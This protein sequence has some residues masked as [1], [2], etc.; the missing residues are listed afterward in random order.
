MHFEK[1]CLTH[2]EW[3]QNDILDYEQLHGKI[4]KNDQTNLI[5]K[6]VRPVDV[7]FW[8]LYHMTWQAKNA[9]GAS[10]LASLHSSVAHMVVCSVTQFYRPRGVVQI[11]GQTAQIRL[12]P[13]GWG[14]KSL[15]TWGD[16]LCVGL[17]VALFY[18]ETAYVILPVVHQV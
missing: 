8:R 4:I 7:F 16:E 9:I 3:V 6:R 15:Q 10:C 5:K 2:Q 18:S 1:P 14:L 12:S 13:S 11:L 17:P